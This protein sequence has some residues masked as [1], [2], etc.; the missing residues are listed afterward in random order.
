M[1]TYYNMP[2][3]PTSA[4]RYVSDIAVFSG[5]WVESGYYNLLYLYKTN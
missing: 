4:E 3:I 1:K 5:G 2:V